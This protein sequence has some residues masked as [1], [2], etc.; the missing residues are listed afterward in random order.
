MYPVSRPR[1]LC[2]VRRTGQRGEHDRSGE[3]LLRD[4]RVTGK[5]DDH[6]AQRDCAYQ[7]LADRTNGT[8]DH[9]YS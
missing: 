1:T 8:R 7:H 3:R 9:Q 5:G 6:M 2:G 4:K